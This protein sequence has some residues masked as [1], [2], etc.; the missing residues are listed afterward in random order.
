MRQNISLHSG[1]A[2]NLR[3]HAALQAS[4]RQ[5]CK[6]IAPV[7]PLENFVAVNPYLG[8]TD[9]KFEQAAQDLATIG[10]IQMTLPVSFYLKK[11]DDGRIQRRDIETV[12]RK[13]PEAADT[14][15][16]EF[17]KALKSTDDNGMDATPIPTVADLATHLTGKDWNSFV[18]SRISAWAASYFDNGQAV[19]SAAHKEDNLFEAWKFEARIDRTPGIAG[20]TGFRQ[21]V[22]LLPDHP[23]EATQKALDIL[24]VPEDSLEVYFHRLLLK[25]GGWSAYAARLDFEHELY[26]GKDGKLI[27]FLAIL[28]CWEA[29]LLQCTGHDEIEKKWYEAKIVLSAAT[30]QKE[31]NRQLAQK[32][33]LQEAFD[34]AVQRDIISKFKRPAVINGKPKRQSKAQ[35]IFCIDVRSEVFRRNLELADNGIET[36]GFAGFFG[37]PIKY[38]PIG[39]T[40]GET[41]CPVLIQHG[42]TVMEQ[43][44]DEQENKLATNRRIIQHQI[45][46]VWKAFKSGAVTCFSFVSP[47]GLSY[48]PKLFTDS[49]GLTRPVPHPDKVGLKDKHSK[50]KAVSLEVATHNHKTTGIPIEQRVQMAR[51]ALN[52]MSLTENFARFV[53]IVGHGSTSVNNPHA[54]GLDCGACAGH[55]GE[56]NAKV[57]AA[58]LNDKTVRAHLAGEG[59]YIPE[60]TVFLAC[61]HDTTTDEV[62]IFNE[63][64]VPG[65]QREALAELKNALVRAGHTSRMERALGMSLEGDTDK[66][67]KMRSKDWSQVRP[68]WGLAGC[69]AFVVAPRYRTSDIDF[70]GRSFLHSYDWKKDRGFA[71]LELIMTAPMVVTNWINLQY[72]A[73]TVDN[74]HFGSGNKTLHNVTAGVGVLEGYSGDLR[75]GLPMQSV[76]NGEDY[77]HEPVRLNVIIEAPVEAINMVLKKHPAVRNLCDNGWLHLLA[78]NE[79][80]RVAHRYVGGL[81]WEDLDSGIVR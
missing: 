51:N 66:A 67:I 58:V 34:L 37:F 18:T 74:K 42:P 24:K 70:G 69:S 1:V 79:L 80:G 52:A 46:Q 7:W 62:S 64:E 59:I 4:M 49:F 21:M 40:D 36:L 28:T 10:G 57:A 56:A 54:T 76:H 71:V 26:G 14:H 23:L 61:L 75:V 50:N 17:I 20:L 41:Q 63:H 32:L 12:L 6:K 9:K 22:N 35:A 15:V 13:R 72:Y 11:I 8:L 53:L 60:N 55:S 5:A 29:C 19:W 3:K 47:V 43:L 2:Y 16:D 77:Q 44:P 45:R 73:S 48:L 31:I 68:E 38:V 25:A 30:V 65:A 33:I 81:Q 78:M 27:A 39:H